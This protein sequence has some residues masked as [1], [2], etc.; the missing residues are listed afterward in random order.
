[1][2]IVGLPYTEPELT[3]TSTGGSPYGASHVAGVGAGRTISDEE[4]RLCVALGRRLATA[5]LK[6]AR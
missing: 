6:L 4:Q 5:A 1:M 2:L 3:S